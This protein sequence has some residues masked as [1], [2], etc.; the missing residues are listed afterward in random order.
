MEGEQVGK[1][2]PAA[3]SLS[4]GLCGLPQ[5]P[6]EKVKLPG[7]PGH[8]AGNTD[9]RQT[10]HSFLELHRLL[11]M[12]TEELDGIGEGHSEIWVHRGITGLV[13]RC[14]CK[15]PPGSPIPRYPVL[16]PSAGWL[17]R[18]EGKGTAW[19]SQHAMG[20]LPAQVSGT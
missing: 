14:T 19:G 13:W 11:I 4:Q 16:P 18:R 6:T 12:G 1:V 5:P 3:L 10:S 8:G 15:P 9:L 2:T 17:E 7:A 20:F